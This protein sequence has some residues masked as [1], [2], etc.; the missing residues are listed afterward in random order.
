MNSKL[1]RLYARATVLMIVLG[2]AFL[3]AAN[4]IR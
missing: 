2:L 1:D 3:L 4:H